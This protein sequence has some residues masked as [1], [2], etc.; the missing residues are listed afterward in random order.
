MSNVNKKVIIII[1]CAVIILALV[2]VGLILISNNAK[3]KENIKPTNT[4]APISETTNI[5][6]I[7]NTPEVEATNIPENTN[8]PEDIN[9]GNDTNEVPPPEEV[10]ETPITEVYA[11]PNPDRF[12]YGMAM[13]PEEIEKITSSEEY[14]NEMHRQDL[15]DQLTI[16]RGINSSGV[17]FY[18]T[19]TYATI[20]KFTGSEKDFDFESRSTVDN[21]YF[22]RLGPDYTNIE[23]YNLEETK[24]NFIV[25]ISEDGHLEIINMYEDI[26]G[27][28][29]FDYVGTDPEL[30]VMITE[31][32]NKLTKDD[33]IS[34]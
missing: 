25:Y 9:L 29:M 6:D 31:I 20:P 16:N 27:Y 17:Q 30:Y 34:K 15:Y 10:E 2:V 8:E 1:I 4:E 24:T 28:I 5:P 32:A 18:K 19:D 21:K 22:P 33:I 23:I 7:E 11:T 12:N 14:K 3:N 26:Y 13:T